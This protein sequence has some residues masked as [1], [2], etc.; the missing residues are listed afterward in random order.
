MKLRMGNLAGTKSGPDE[1]L[2]A[3]ESGEKA[4]S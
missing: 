1:V 3:E 2:R 4:R